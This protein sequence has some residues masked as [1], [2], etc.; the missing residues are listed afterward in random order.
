MLKDTLITVRNF[1]DTDP[2]YYPILNTSLQNLRDRDNQLA[3]AIDA[4]GG[5][6]GSLVDITGG[7]SPSVNYLPSGWSFS[8][9]G[10]GVY[11]ITHNLGTTSYSVFPS[12][13]SSSPLLISVNNKTSNTFTINMVNLG[14]ASVDARFNCFIPRY[15]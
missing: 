3:D 12:I 10:A 11:V 9:S 6:G 15:G 14:N 13:V 1:E 7:A 5:L 2:W 4:G 8:R